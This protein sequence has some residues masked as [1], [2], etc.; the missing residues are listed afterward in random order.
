[1]LSYLPNY[2]HTKINYFLK[3][4]SKNLICFCNFSNFYFKL[5]HTHKYKNLIYDCKNMASLD[6]KVAKIACFTWLLILTQYIK[7]EF[8]RSVREK[9]FRNNNE[10]RYLFREHLIKVRT[11][12]CVLVYYSENWSMCTS[13]L[14]RTGVCVLVYYWELEYV[15]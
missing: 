12:V 6:C 9:W 5:F 11:G 14:L 8:K 2:W 4:T 7:W 10:I 3:F 1:M 15:Y 13:V